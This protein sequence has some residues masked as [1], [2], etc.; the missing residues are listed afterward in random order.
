MNLITSEKGS[1]SI[2][3]TIV[4]AIVTMVLAYFLSMTAGVPGSIHDSAETTLHLLADGGGQGWA[5]NGDETVFITDTGRK[6]HSYD[7]PTVMQ[8]LRPV[9]LKDVYESHKPCKLCIIK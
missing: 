5:G 6:Y 8:S 9:R 2:E 3:A 1:L 7:C 4:M